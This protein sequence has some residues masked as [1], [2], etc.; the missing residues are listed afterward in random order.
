MLRQ[1]SYGFRKRVSSYGCYDVNGYR[2]R[3][4]K[5]ER[6]KTLATTNSGVCVACTDGDGNVLEYFGVIEDIIKISWEGREQLDLILF[7]CRWFDPTS[8]GVRRT[9]NLGL[10]EVKHSSRLRNF[11]P[12]VLASQ[13]TQVYYLS[14]PC[15]DKPNLRDWWV[16]Y[17]A[18]P[19][20]R[21]P[22]I[23]TNN[24]ST[25]P[26]EGPIDDISFFQEDGLEGTF[27]INLGGDFEVTASAASDE[28]T[29]AKELEELEKQSV[30]LQQDE[31]LQSDE[32]GEEDDAESYD[33]DCYEEE[34]F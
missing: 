3:S 24:D 13:V 2:F 33:E 19:R 34:D 7:Y 21:L 23:D 16:V 32:E 11:E 4:E 6:N 20:D 15:V 17:H 29:D 12:F 9:E 30:G 28:I 22:P 26:T 14:Y 5:Y 27:V 31:T 25:N 1:I 18:A 10:V 8:R